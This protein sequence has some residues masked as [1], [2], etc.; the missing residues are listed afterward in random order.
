MGWSLN[1][2][3]IAGTEIKIHITFL[4]FLIWIFASSYVTG[5]PQAA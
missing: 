2:G 1:I 5:G 4:L 3:R